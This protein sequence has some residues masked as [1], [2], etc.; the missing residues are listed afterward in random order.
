MD[1]ST[2][3]SLTVNPTTRAQK[4]L[5]A[6]L[7]RGLGGSPEEVIERRH[8]VAGMLAFRG[9][10]RLAPGSGEHIQALSPRRAQMPILYCGG[11][12]CE[13]TSRPGTPR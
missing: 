13:T 2:G 12:P 6:A 9:E 5:G 4:L 3:R 11:S 10:L 8:A 7:A 1:R